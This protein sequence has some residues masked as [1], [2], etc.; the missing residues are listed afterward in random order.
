MN[1]WTNELTDEELLRFLADN[2]YR[3]CSGGYYDAGR[4]LLEIADKTARMNLPKEVRNLLEELSR[5]GKKYDK[6]YLSDSDTGGCISE[7][8]LQSRRARKLLE[9]ESHG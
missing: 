4:R 9:G 1:S 2:D 8:M 3:T 6:P 7:F 5:T